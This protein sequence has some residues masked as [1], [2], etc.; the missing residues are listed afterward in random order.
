[1]GERG[2]EWEREGGYRETDRH[3][4]TDRERDTHTQTDSF[5]YL[6]I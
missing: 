4:Q 6:F 2:R 5:V 1:M 3:T